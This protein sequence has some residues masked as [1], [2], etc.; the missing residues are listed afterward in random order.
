[1]FPEDTELSG[2]PSLRL[3]IASDVPDTDLQATI[4]EVRPDGTAAL[5]SN[6]RLRLRYREDLRKPQPLPLNQAVEITFKDFSF[7]SQQIS[8]ESR[9]R[10]ALGYRSTPYGERNPN[11]GGVVAKESRDKAQIA[12]LRVLM[13]PQHASVLHLPRPKALAQPEAAAAS[14]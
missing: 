8:K 6:C 13:D 11:T 9:I 7:F 14:R 2:I 3:W 5:L 1:P 4:A 10:L 12:T